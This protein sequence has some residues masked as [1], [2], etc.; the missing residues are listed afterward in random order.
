MANKIIALTELISGVKITPQLQ[1]AH[2][3]AYHDVSTNTDL[4]LLINDIGVIDRLKAFIQKGTFGVLK[5]YEEWNQNY[6]NKELD[7]L[8]CGLVCPINIEN[9]ED[10]EIDFYFTEQYNY[11]NFIR[12]HG[13]TVKLRKINEP[14][15]SKYRRDKEREY[16]LKA[17]KEDNPQIFFETELRNQAS[18]NV[19]RDRKNNW[20]NS[21]LIKEKEFGL[22]LEAEKVRNENKNPTCQGILLTLYENL[23]NMGYEKIINHFPK[24][25]ED[26]IFRATKNY[27]HLAN[28]SNKEKLDYVWKPIKFENNFYGGK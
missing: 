6:K 10:I 15:F 11:H 28:K 25:S 17:L 13:R 8:S 9:I 24:E 26:A 18:R 7:H 5:K 2:A 23:A 3:G 1:E 14:K 20:R 12:C 27:Q 22:E 4:G 16:W 21:G 19:Q